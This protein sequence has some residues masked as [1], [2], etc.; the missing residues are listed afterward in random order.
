MRILFTPSY[1]PMAKKVKKVKT[2][3]GLKL[4]IVNPN[5][6]GIDYACL[7]CNRSAAYHRFFLQKH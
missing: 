5:A 3:K 1:I 2:G 7:F 4:E 6:V